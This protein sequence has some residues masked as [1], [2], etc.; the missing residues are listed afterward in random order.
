MVFYSVSVK[1][2]HEDVLYDILFVNKI[3]P[4]LTNYEIIMQTSKDLH[5][6]S[7]LH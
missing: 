4:T 7:V 3:I 5:S 6:T 2:C 1:L